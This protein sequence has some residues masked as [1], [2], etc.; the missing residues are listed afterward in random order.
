MR[1]FGG[2][3]FASEIARSTTLPS[4][5][6]SRMPSSST[7]AAGTAEP[8]SMNSSAARAPINRGKRC[9]PP[10][11]GSSPSLISGRPSFERGVA[12]R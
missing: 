2:I 9:V 11:P 4:T 8:F 6:S 10:A 7:R 12:M 1:R 3:S 5:I